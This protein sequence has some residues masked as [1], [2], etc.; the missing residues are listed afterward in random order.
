MPKS[1]P[2]TVYIQSVVPNAESSCPVPFLP[3]FTSRLDQT[4]VHRDGGEHFLLLWRCN[5]QRDGL[6]LYL[7]V[8]GRSPRALSHCFIYTARPPCRNINQPSCWVSATGSGGR[9]GSPPSFSPLPQASH[10]TWRKLTVINRCGFYSFL[11]RFTSSSCRG[12][13]KHLLLIGWQV[14]FRQKGPIY[15]KLQVTVETNTL[16]VIIHENGSM[17][18]CTLTI[19]WSDG[20]TK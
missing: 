17:S 11:Y 20:R 16:S 8:P 15:V 10:L 2:L 13:R 4:G 3:G 19:H 14:K 1:L 7:E 9:A 6:I 12:Y 5:W 18:Y